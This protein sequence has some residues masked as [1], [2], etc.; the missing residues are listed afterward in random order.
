[1]SL[2]SGLALTLGLLLCGTP[3][4]TLG[5]P[6]PE[7]DS[8]GKAPALTISQGQ[9]TGVYQRT[10]DGN[11]FMAFYGIPYAKPPV[12]ELRFKAPEPADKWEGV[13]EARTEGNICPQPMKPMKR[14][15]GA[16][17]KMMGMMK[18]MA[19]L[20]NMPAFAAKHMTGM[21][22]DCLFLNVYSPNLAATLAM[23]ESA[24][25]EI[26]LNPVLVFFHGGAFS[27]G[28]ADAMM[29]GADLL[30]SKGVVLVTVNYRLGPLGFLA[31]NSADAPGNAGLKDQR[32]ALRW[33]RDNIKVFGGDPDKVTIYGESAG[34]YSVH[35]HVLSPSSAGLFRAAILSSSMG[36]DVYGFQEN[37]AAVSERL[38]EALGADAATVA[39]P[40]K[41]VEFLRGVSAKDMLSKMMGAVQDSDLNSIS[42]AFPWAVVAEP[43]DTPDAFLT[44]NPNDLLQKGE[45]NRVPLMVGMNNQ[46][47]SLVIPMLTDEELQNM[48][49]NPV[50]F[51]PDAMQK[52]LDEGG[53]AELAKKIVDLYFKG[54]PV[55]EATIPQL[56]ELFGDETLA[57][58]INV[59]TRWHV[60]HATPEAPVYVYLFTMDA[61]GGVSWLLGAEKIIKGA[62][63]G[64]DLSYVF[65]P[66]L[67]DGLE[68][69]DQAKL[70]QGRARMT[71]LIS[72]FVKDKSPTA[73]KTEDAPVDWPAAT[74]GN[75]KYL[76]IGDELVVKDGLPFPERMAF[77]DKTSKEV[78]KDPIYDV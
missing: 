56:I 74:P 50:R 12:G 4:S 31:T 71:Q 55:A 1:M 9:I 38:A 23:E 13:L 47:G 49:E 14:F 63:H 16:T 65:Q 30:M 10:A 26:K 37:P 18:K 58:G 8:S 2:A 6:I 73:T 61:F 52:K 29:Y 34:A 77:W 5:V 75:I 27:V 57:H 33:V 22:E 69:P 48:A 46:E 40:A 25:N 76:D 7:Q 72:A 44:A 19:G 43:A 45:F 24:L 78:L 70:D 3:P 54:Q 35:M 59:G 68:V 17:K 66:H 15:A 20:P 42:I 36:P 32:L 67:L 60:K 11:N 41:R 51:V 53:R 39:D 62:G 21:K 28:N 64:D